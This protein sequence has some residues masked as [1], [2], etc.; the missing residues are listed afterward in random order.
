M[1]NRK[2]PLRVGR[3]SVSAAGTWPR[4][5][6]ISVPWLSP[7]AIAR[8]RTSP[9]PGGGISSCRSST[10]RG[11]GNQTLVARLV[12]ADGLRMGEAAMEDDILSEGSEVC[13]GEP[14][15]I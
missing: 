2:L 9:G 5:T 12:R 6:S 10:R 3:S 15:R 11:L 7:D 1:G 8:T 4:K 13:L 14:Q